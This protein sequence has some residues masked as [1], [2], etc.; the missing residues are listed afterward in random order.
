MKRPRVNSRSS[1]PRLQLSQHMR[2][3]ASTGSPP[4]GQVIV[5]LQADSS[6]HRQIRPCRQLNLIQTISK[7]D[8]VCVIVT[9]RKISVVWV[10]CA[11]MVAECLD[12][13]SAA[14]LIRNT[15]GHH[16]SQHIS[17]RQQQQAGCM[18]WK[19]NISGL[20]TLNKEAPQWLFRGLLEMIIL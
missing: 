10:M 11:V 15:R 2:F 5:R 19:K 17:R 8:A 13:S 6:P 18:R 12:M 14:A 1:I 9:I 16:S 3:E 4:A 7:G 20:A